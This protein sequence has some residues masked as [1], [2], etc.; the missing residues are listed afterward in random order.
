MSRHTR[1]PSTC[2]NMV[3][4]GLRRVTS[5]NSS[6][7][8]SNSIHDQTNKAPA[9]V[10]HQWNPM[11]SSLESSALQAAGIGWSWEQMCLLCCKPEV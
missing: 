6:S 8:L 4:V 1:D 9:Q 10:Q 11:E 5:N 3:R 7:R 2:S